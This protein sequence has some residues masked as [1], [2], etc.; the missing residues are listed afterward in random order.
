VIPHPWVT[1]PLGELVDV[2]DHRRIP[3]NK[4]ERANRQGS[5]PY[6]GA[7]GQAG[8]I[9]DALFDEPLLLLG[10]DGV[11]FFDRGKPKAYLVDGPAW[12]NN[13]A[14]VLRVRDSLADRRF[15][16]YQMNWMDY[17]GYANG[18]TR[19]KLTKSAMA[20]MSIRLPVLAEQRRIVE[21]LEDHL[22]RLEVAE[23]LVS[24]AERRLGSWQKVLL[25]RVIWANA[26]AAGS[27]RDLVD[28][29]EAGKSFGGSAPPARE[30]Q[31]GVIKVSAMTW[32]QFKPEE[33]KAV[34]G[35]R[36]DPRCA[37]RA[38]DL[39][40]SR[41]NTTEY[42]GAPVLVE[43]TPP[44]LLLSDKSL[45]LVP[46]ADVDPRWLVQVLAAPSTRRQIS[47]R[48]T[49]T[50]DSMR[51]ISQASLLRIRVPRATPAEQSQTVSLAET[52]EAASATARTELGKAKVRASHLRRALLTAAFAGRL[53]GEKLSNDVGQEH[54]G[55]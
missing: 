49:G 11:Q 21:I 26:S 16:M 18:T 41:A 30:D 35:G 23:Q 24:G 53:T 2:L 52:V 20:R 34:S 12:V 10:E 7:T 37:I 28:R 4:K 47:E 19:L 6:Y 43:S 25:D 51:N 42:V 29:I 13:H 48:A 40:V 32:G 5:I 31:W 15:L 54:A 44:R 14:H 8:W 50:K 3:V 55:V 22:S 27:L 17:H 46:R 39:L 9:D 33:N 45:R 1:R 36:V 38:G